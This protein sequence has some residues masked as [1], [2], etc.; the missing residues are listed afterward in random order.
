MFFVREQRFKQEFARQRNSLAN[1]YLM[2]KYYEI[3]FRS[4]SQL[5]AMFIALKATVLFH[6]CLKRSIAYSNM[7]EK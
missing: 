1:I 7:R 4:Y 6:M 5:I 2:L 3:T